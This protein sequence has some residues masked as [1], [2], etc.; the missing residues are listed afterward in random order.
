MDS[1]K[2]VIQWLNDLAYSVATWDLDAHMALVSERVEVSIPGVDRI[3][4]HGWKLRR[5]NEFKKKLIHSLYHRNIQILEARPDFISFGV[6]EQIRDHSNKC[7][8]LKKEVTLHQ[9]Q[10]GKWKVVREDVLSV[11]AKR[12]C[13]IA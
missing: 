11:E 7:I 4:Y 10:A 8:E 9:E 5:H 12:S 6:Q 1:N 3:D 13:A 2:I